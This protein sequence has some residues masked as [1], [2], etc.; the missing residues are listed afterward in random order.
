MF[1]VVV[2]DGEPAPEDADLLRFA[3]LVIAVDGGARWLSAHA[4]RPH[5]VVGDLDSLDQPSIEQL[6]ASGTRV[7]RHPVK[8][9]ASDTELAVEAAVSAG[10]DRIVVL[11]AFGGSRLDHEL[12]NVL[13][14][15]DPAFAPVDIELR[16]GGTLVRAVTGTGRLMLQA[17]VGGTVTLLPLGGEAVGVTT[18]GLRYA[19]D[20]ESLAT[21]RSRGLSNEVSALPASV[22]LRGGSLLVIELDITKE[23]E[24]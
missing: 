1:A 19:L 23:G 2:A 3:D 22:S 4:V 14:L 16:R 7:S 13:L 12:A 6:Q 15:V 5:I 9:D 10:A 18:R 20:D 21:G 17:A 24:S 8:K 11:G